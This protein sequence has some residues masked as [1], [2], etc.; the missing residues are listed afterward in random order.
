[1]RSME[2]CVTIAQESRFQMTDDDGVSHLFVLHRNASIEP[3]QLEPL[4][5][6]QR[7][8]RVRYEPAT[9]LIAHVARSVELCNAA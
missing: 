3:E 4:Q 8:V 7:R 2:G 1:M 5:K 6:G 9:G